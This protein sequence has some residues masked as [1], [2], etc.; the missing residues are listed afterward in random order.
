M[1]TIPAASTGMKP[2]FVTSWEATRP[3]DDRQSQRQVGQ[4]RLDR[5]VVE[6]LLM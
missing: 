3:W 1:N 2:T 4:A 5:A 6:H